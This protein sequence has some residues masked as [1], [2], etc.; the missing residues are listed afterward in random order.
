[1]LDLLEAERT[2]ND[3]RLAMAQAMSD[4]ANA[5]T[6]LQAATEGMNPQNQ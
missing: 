2:D 5:V 4:A 1:L 3:A 6:D